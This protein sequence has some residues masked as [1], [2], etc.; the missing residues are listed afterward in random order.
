MVMSRLVFDPGRQ[1][2]PGHAEYA[3]DAAH[4]GTFRLRPEE[5]FLAFR[6]VIVLRRQAANR[7]AVCA[8]RLLT[9]AL[10][11]SIFHHV[12]AAAFATLLLNRCDDHLTILFEDDFVDKKI[13]LSF[14]VYHYPNFETSK[15]RLH[16]FNVL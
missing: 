10:I 9:P 8:Q 5:F 11:S 13:H 4:P 1:R 6:A 3:A 15:V 7:P 2:V 16:L 12:G 14:K